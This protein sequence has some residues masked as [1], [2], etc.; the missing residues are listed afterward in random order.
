MALRDINKGDDLN[1]FGPGKHKWLRQ[2]DSD[3]YLV[4]VQ[5]MKGQER[6]YLSDAN[7]HNLKAE[8][9]Q[10]ALDAQ[11]GKDRFKVKPHGSHKYIICMKDKED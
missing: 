10:A 9:M 3:S 1:K 5:E 4:D 8:D 6:V 11:W 7:S 2:T